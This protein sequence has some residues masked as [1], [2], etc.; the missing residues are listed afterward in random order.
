M[1]PNLGPEYTR[2]FSEIYPR[3]AQKHNIILIPFFLE[4]VAGSDTLNQSDKL[5]PTANGYTRIV[6]TVY[7]F[8][9]DA[10]NRHATKSPGQTN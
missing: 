10:I 4:G 3:V 9:L 2:A 8:V 1:L 7:P 6:E 5:H